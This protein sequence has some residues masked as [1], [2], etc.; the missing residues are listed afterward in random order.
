[1]PKSIFFRI[2]FFLVIVV[3][4]LFLF[5]TNAQSQVFKSNSTR[6]QAWIEEHFSKGK[7]PPFSFTYSGVNSD[8]FITKWKYTSEK[9]MINDEITKY[10]FTYTDRKS[11]LK[12]VCDVTAYNRFNAVEWVLNYINN[13]EKDSEIIEEVQAIDQ[14]FAYKEGGAFKLHYAK[15]SNASYTDFMPLEREFKSD[16]DFYMTTT[17]G[18]GSSDET[19]FPF[20]NVERKGQGGFVVAIGWSGKWYARL[21]RKNVNSILIQGGMET[22]QLALFPG[23]KIRTPSICLLFWDGDDRMVGHNNFRQFILAHHSPRVNGKVIDGPLSAFIAPDGPKPCEWSACLTEAV[24]L[25]TIDRFR[26]FGIIPEVSWIDAGWFPCDK[27]WWTGLGNMFPDKRRFPRGLKP[28]SEAAHA[29]GSK[30]LVWFDVEIAK[31]GTKVAMEHPE[32]LLKSKET[33]NKDDFWN[34]NSYLF[35]L[36]NPE[37]RLWITDYITDFLKKEN[38]DIYRQDFNMMNFK[39]CW[40]LKDK[41][42]RIGMAE[43]RYIEGLYAFWDSLRARIPELIIDNC[44]SGGRRIDLETVSRSIPLWRSDYFWEPNGIQNQTYGLNFYLPLHGLDAF[45]EKPYE[46]RSSL[47]SALTLRWDVYNSGNSIS[48]MQKDIEEFKMLR[49]YYKG[50]YY[51]LT[52]SENL[53]SDSVWLAYQMNRPDK[54]DGFIIAFRRQNSSENR[55][56]VKLG[57]LASDANYEI[58]DKDSGKQERRTGKELSNQFIIELDK[59]ASSVIFLYKKT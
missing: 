22:M 25:G 9:S 26:Q 1:M 34:Y 59:P 42:G 16:E 43:I 28:V 48:Q 2:T 36:G 55:I 58:T 19:G 20:F 14:S 57:G 53:L 24:A 39:D 18:Q 31:K 7:T 12:V 23:E 5:F 46:F 3:F 47:S 15:G 54:E 44:A 10:Q 37:A 50:D 49:P 29:I 30:L 11:K 51:P 45:S 33:D 38:I 21:Q 8:A 4:D 41:P 17:G 52:D 35:D 32:W 27:G 6:A 13:G 40:E 56:R